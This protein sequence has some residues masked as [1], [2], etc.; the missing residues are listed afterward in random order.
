MRSITGI[1]DN[2]LDI[3]LELYA[4]S[5]DYVEDIELRDIFGHRIPELESALTP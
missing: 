2:E 4:L 5:G 3:L 1:A